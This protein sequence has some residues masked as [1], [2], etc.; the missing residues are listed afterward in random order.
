MDRCGTFIY[1]VRMIFYSFTF[2]GAEVLNS[3]GLYIG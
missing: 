1:L 2:W 3:A